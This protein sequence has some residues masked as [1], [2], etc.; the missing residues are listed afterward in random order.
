MKPIE[1]LPEDLCIRALNTLCFQLATSVGREPKVG[2][3]LSGEDIKEIF[4]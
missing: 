2:E 1:D 3:C 4:K